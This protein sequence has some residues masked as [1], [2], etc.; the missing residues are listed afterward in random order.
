MRFAR[1]LAPLLAA[2]V[3]AGACTV[4][5]SE[6]QRELFPGN[7]PYK[8]AKSVFDVLIERQV[9][10]PNSPQ[11]LNAAITGIENQLKKDGVDA[12]AVDHPRFTGSPQSDFAKFSD[13]LEAAL[14]R[15]PNEKPVGLERAASDAMAKA[16]NDC[17]T[18]YLDPDRAKG[19]NQPSP[20]VSGIGVIIEKPTP[21]SPV[22][23]LSVIPRTPAERAGVQP[24]DEFISVEGVD[25][26][27]YQTDELANKVR[28]PE[29]TTVNLVL[30]RG[31]QDVSF[32]IVRARFSAPLETDKLID[33]TIGYIQIPQLVGDVAQQVSDAVHRLDAAGAK[34]WVL[35][36][37]SDP[38]GDLTAAQD[39]AGIWVRKGI[40]V[41]QTDRD[42]QRTE[43]DG[44]ARFFFAKPKPLVVLV[45]QDSY[46]GAEI[47]A[48]GVRA[49][50]AGTLLGTHTG[51]C[52]GTAQPRELPDGG[53]LLVTLTR[54]QDAKTGD[55]LN[56]PG[57]GLLPD[58][59]VPSDK[60][61][62]PDNQLQAAVD[63][64]KP[65]I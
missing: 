8:T 14:R 45:N 46:S 50:D 22:H 48:A 5:P 29:G 1:A 10:K 61:V 33:G 16:V 41:L 49:N 57:R 54:M 11:L 28:G 43:V 59:T 38:G 64:L 2:I 27:N 17:H 56:V 35:D 34:A 13:S 32:S 65:K 44:N 55:N 12:P 15:Y 63:Y 47:I 31:T 3:I 30:R 53:L 52:V 58:V 20:P 19:F 62:V 25:V 6:I 40:L 4:V 23:V 26:T 39:V 37:R 36:L 9:D 60:S 21:D 18:Y 42:G 7:T 51:G 24:G